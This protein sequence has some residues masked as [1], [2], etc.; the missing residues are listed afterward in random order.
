MVCKVCNNTYL[1]LISK[2]KLSATKMFVNKKTECIIKRCA[3]PQ[4]NFLQDIFYKSLILAQIERW[5]RA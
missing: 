5:R 3:T 1:A 4:I 2:R